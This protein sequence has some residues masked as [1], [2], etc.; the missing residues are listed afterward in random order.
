MRKLPNGI[1]GRDGI[2]PWSETFVSAL[3]CLSAAH[4]SVLPPDLLSNIWREWGLP[5]GETDGQLLKLVINFPFILFRAKC[6]PPLDVS[7][8]APNHKHSPSHPLASLG[9]DAGK[10]FELIERKVFAD[11]IGWAQAD[12]G[13]LKSGAFIQDGGST[14]F[15]FGNGC[16]SPQRGT[17]AVLLPPLPSLQ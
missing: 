14:L 8:Q 2:W 16:S 17:L 7:L 12:V 9:A 10:V 1:L 3:S 13:A 11:E 5:V 15:P 4:G 6:T